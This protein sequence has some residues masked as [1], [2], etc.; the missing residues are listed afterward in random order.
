MNNFFLKIYLEFF[1][2][3]ALLFCSS[4]FAACILDYISTF[5]LKVK[6]SFRKLL[7]TSFFISLCTWFFAGTFTS[8]HF[9]IG[10]FFQINSV[11]LLLTIGLGSCILFYFSGSF[12]SV[13]NF[14]PEITVRRDKILLASLI[15]CISLPCIAIIFYIKIFIVPQYF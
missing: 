2:F 5:F 10:Y 7:Y 13:F 1:I 4:F 11:K 15:S 3:T 6:V 12:V 9:I 14:Y 8:V